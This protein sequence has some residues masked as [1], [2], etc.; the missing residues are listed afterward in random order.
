M[1]KYEFAINWQS[2]RYAV[3]PHTNFFAAEGAQDTCSALLWHLGYH[4]L[5][6]MSA[7]AVL[8]MMVCSNSKLQ[9]DSR[10]V[11]YILSHSV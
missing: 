8:C 10:N 2:T 11:L 1:H 9:G 4:L 3:A 5:I 6:R 7:G